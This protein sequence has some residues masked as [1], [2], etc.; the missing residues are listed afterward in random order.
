MIRRGHPQPGRLG[1]PLVFTADV[2]ARER[3]AAPHR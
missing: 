3:R 2:A 1:S